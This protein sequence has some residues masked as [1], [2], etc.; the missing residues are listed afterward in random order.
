MQVSAEEFVKLVAEK[1]P[2]EIF[3][4]TVISS[5]DWQTH[6]LFF[7]DCGTRIQIS[8]EHSAHVKPEVLEAIMQM[9]GRAES[10]SDDPRELRSIP[11]PADLLQK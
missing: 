2:E 11:R 1:K 10:N 6:T 3:Y 7:D 4:R 5:F 9:I 8:F